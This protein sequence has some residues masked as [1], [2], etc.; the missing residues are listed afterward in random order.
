MDTHEGGSFDVDILRVREEEGEEGVR[1]RDREHRLSR[2][3][4][5]HTAC[6]QV[7]PLQE[8]GSILQLLDLT[9]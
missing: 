9:L 1:V 2:G 8:C 5:A 7:G 4:P 6:V 3:P